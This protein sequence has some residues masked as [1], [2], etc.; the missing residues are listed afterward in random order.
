MADKRS[1][2]AAGCLCHKL[3]YK[4][5][6]R[7]LWSECCEG[8]CFLIRLTSFCLPFLYSLESNKD[9][10]MEGK[11]Q[12]CFKVQLY[13]IISY[14][15]S[16]IP[17]HLSAFNPAL[18]FSA[19]KAELCL[20]DWM[21]PSI[22]ETLDLH[23]HCIRALKIVE[24]DEINSHNW[25]Q[26]SEPGPQWARYP[27]PGDLNTVTVAHS[28]WP[29]WLCVPSRGTSELCSNSKILLDGGCMKK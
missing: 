15:S 26:E 6:P 5:E 19:Y 16:L 21:C 18:V 27:G 9:R 29:V 12:A 20:W 28:H 2:P 11:D 14:L 8:M 24:K 13:S 7:P 10:M 4:C 23:T 25:V 22:L 17:H 1:R 3:H